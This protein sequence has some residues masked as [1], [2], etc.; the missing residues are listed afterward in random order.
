MD[1]GVAGAAAASL[2]AETVIPE[3]RQYRDWVLRDYQCGELEPIS[4]GW[5]DE[6]WLGTWRD[7]NWA[8]G[9]S[10]GQVLILRKGS[11]AVR[12]FAPVDLTDEDILENVRA[13]LGL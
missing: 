13:R 6:A 12:V 8:M 3:Y 9:E 7:Y 10:R 4:L 1:W 2:R 11:V 5:A